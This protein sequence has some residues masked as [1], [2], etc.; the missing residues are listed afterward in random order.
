MNSKQQ[1]IF[2]ELKRRMNYLQDELGYEVLFIALQGSQN[3][4]MDI[5]T[6]EYKSDLDCMAVVLPSFDDFVSNKQAVSTTYVLPSNEHINVKDIRLMFELFYKQNPQFLEL[7]FTDYKIVNKK[8]RLEVQSLFA[9]ANKIASYNLL[10]LYNG[11]SGMAQEKFKALEHPYPSIVDKIEKYGYDGKQLH[12]IIRLYQFITNLMNGMSYKDAMTYFEP[13]IRYMCMESKLNEFSLE[14]ARDLA[15]VYS[16]KIHTMKEEYFEKNEVE[17][18][19]EVVEILLDIK[20]NI[21]RKFFKEDLLPD[22]KEPFKLCPDQYKKVWVTSD[23]HFGHNNILS[24]ENRV[25]KLK[26]A[27]VEE[28]DKELIRRWNAIVG[29]DDLVLILGDFSFKKSKDTEELLKE[30]N[31]DKVLV[32]GNHDVF[33]DDKTFDKS[34]FKA[35]YDYKETKYKGQEI[36]LMHYPIQDFKHQSRETKPAVLLFGH[37]HTFNV[38]I[39]KHSF[40]VGVD[41]NNYYPVDLVEAISKALN[42]TGGLMNGRQ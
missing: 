16:E 35:I 2:K 22:Y 7:L 14:E 21:L 23:T 37:I 32:R 34:L 11:I 15:R 42:N 17:I 30:L 6:E 4:G 20:L 25:E 9:N 19:D 40:N 26:V 1:E 24:Y 10:K 12:H 38:E 27:T 39:P 18:K 13:D 28:H 29:K 41:V 31:G 3:Y 5:Y 36:A 33:L 8:Y